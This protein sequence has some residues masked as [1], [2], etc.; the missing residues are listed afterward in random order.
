MAGAPAKASRGLNAPPGL[1]PKRRHR[2]PG[3]RPPHANSPGRVL[4][5]LDITVIVNRARK[6]EKSKKS[7][8]DEKV[9]KIEKDF[10]ILL[11]LK[12]MQAKF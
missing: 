11:K 2:N 12:G 9:E 4:N 8:K 10:P 5:Y 1:P 7:E 3:P 6:V